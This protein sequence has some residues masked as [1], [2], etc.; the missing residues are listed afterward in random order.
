MSNGIEC[1]RHSGDSNPVS[2]RCRAGK[3]EF[4][5]GTSLVAE[6]RRCWSEFLR[7]LRKRKKRQ[8][9]DF[10]GLR[11]FELPPGGQGLRLRAVE[12]V[13]SGN[14]WYWQPPGEASRKPDARN[15]AGF[16]RG[17]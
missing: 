8:G 5:S 2:P 1:R 11:V 16:L 3:N 13:L 15:G 14:P 9:L 10:Q 12:D 7:K 4:R 17:G 6:G